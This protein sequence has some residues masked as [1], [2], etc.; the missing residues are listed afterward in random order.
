MKITPALASSALKVVA[1]ETE[2]EHRV[3]R[4]APSARRPRRSHADAEQHLLLAQRNAELLVGREDFRIDLV[5]RLRPGLLLRR[6]VVIE[7]L[8]VDLRII[9]PRPVRLAHGQPAPIGVEPPL[10][11]PFRLALLRRDEADGVLGQALRGLLGFDQRSRIHTCID[12]RRCGG[13]DRP[14]LGRPAFVPPLRFQGPRVGFSRL[15]SVSWLRVTLASSDRCGEFAQFA[16]I[17][18]RRLLSL[19]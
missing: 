2:V 17:R 5:E 6:G 3:D 12:R 13:P 7:V 9:D 10:Q 15:W 16:A 4:D 14:S 11:H 1:T 19:R 8:V 18:R